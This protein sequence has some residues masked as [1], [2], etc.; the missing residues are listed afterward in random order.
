MTTAAT[1]AIA[2]LMGMAFDQLGYRRL[3][4][5][6]DALNEASAAAALRLGFTYEGTFRKATIYKGRNRDTAW[7]AIVDDD[8][9]GIRLALETWL[10]PANFDEAGKQIRSL[11]AIRTPGA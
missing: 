1:E 7:Y 3:E 9:P 11:Q 8:W 2:M 4:W 10:D 6:A 5:K